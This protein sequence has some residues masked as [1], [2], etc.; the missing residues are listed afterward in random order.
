MA[1]SGGGDS[2][3]LLLLAKAWADR[4]GRPLVALTVDHCL[5]PQSTA[6]AGWCAA[7][8]ADLGV[9]HT[10]LVWDGPKPSRGL[11]AAARG[12]RHRLIADAARQAGAKVILFGHTA[13]DVIESQLMSAAGVR[14]SP[15]AAWSPSPVWPEGRDLFILRPLIAV[16]RAAIR[17]WLVARGETWIDDPA[18]EDMRHPRVRARAAMTDATGE[19]DSAAPASQQVFD[20]AAIGPSGEISLPLNNRNSKSCGL[21]RLGSALVCVA[22]SER[23]PRRG[24]LERLATR[25]A[26]G[27]A[28]EATLG[29]ARVVQT[30]DLLILARETG[31]ARGRACRPMTLRAGEQQVWDGRFEVRA[32]APGLILTALHGHAARLAVGQ[33]RALSGLHPAARA[34]LPAAI[35]EHGA[36][37]CPTLTPDP[38]LDI[39]SLVGGRL[40]GA[41]GAIDSEAQ[42]GVYS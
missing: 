1:L 16:R 18:N 20:R 28:V 24:A 8:A 36:V 12:A 37:V 5:Q 34:A 2:L 30:L 33:R 42:I 29:G 6:W 26:A 13:D 25:L 3:A 21:P 9:A 39:R 10:I 22:G 35:D 31:D 38:R 23:P 7:R 4:H 15:P 27:G 41:S 14:I 40:A 19:S 17:A 32:H 11:P